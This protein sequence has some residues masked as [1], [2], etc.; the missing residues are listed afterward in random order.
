VSDGATRLLAKLR[1]LVESCDAEERAVLAVLLA[2]GLS[3]VYDGDDDVR[4]FAMPEWQPQS[5]ADA[6]TA[7]VERRGLRAADGPDAPDGG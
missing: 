4:G 3:E 6:L 1:S 5:L 2:P 7:A